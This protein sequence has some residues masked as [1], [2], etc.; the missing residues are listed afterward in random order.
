MQKKVVLPN[1]LKFSEIA[2]H[3]GGRAAQDINRRRAFHEFAHNTDKAADKF[4][5]SFEWQRRREEALL[6]KHNGNIYNAVEE[7]I[8]PGL[9]ATKQLEALPLDK[10]I[11][12]EIYQEQH[13]KRF[14][15][16][17]RKGEHWERWIA[18]GEDSRPIGK[19]STRAQL[20]FGMG[21][22]IRLLSSA[23]IPEDFPKVEK[24]G[25][26]KSIFEI[27]IIGRTNVGKSCLMNALLNSFV[28]EYDCTPGTTLSCNFYDIA[29]RLRLVDMPG[30]GYVS[31]LRAPVTTVECAQ[32]TM[33]QYLH[34]ASEGKRNVPRVLLCI[35]GDL[36]LHQAD[37]TFLELLESLRLNFTVVMT[38]TDEVQIKRLVRIVDYTRCQLVHYRYCQELMM[39]SSLRLCGITKL[40]NLIGNIG[41]RKTAPMDEDDIDLKRVM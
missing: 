38:K 27:P 16:T 17:L 37:H 4:I 3:L 11:V 22:S 23:R 28:A 5:S 15:R 18:R 14:Q 7:F 39:V 20:T 24:S 32:S 8:R 31:P 35:S 2:N 19:A 33:K 1:S 10:K 9:S 36:G 30:Y 6:R 21:G 34:M 13:G 12:E 26:K 25:K 40:Q 41:S 29:K